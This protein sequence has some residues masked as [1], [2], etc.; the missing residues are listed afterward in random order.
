VTPHGDHGFGAAKRTLKT[1]GFGSAPTQRQWV[2]DEIVRLERVIARGTPLRVTTSR[3]ILH[4]RM[5]GHVGTG[6]NVRG[7]VFD[8]I[9]RRLPSVSIVVS[10]GD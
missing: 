6:D 8:L 7:E 4:A 3:N 9:S 10:E 5:F 1:D 2:A